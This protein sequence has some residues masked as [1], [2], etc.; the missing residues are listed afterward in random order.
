MAFVA[1]ARED[2]Q[3]IAREL[4]RSGWQ[5][6]GREKHEKQTADHWAINRI[7]QARES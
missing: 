2:R 4:G 7:R 6:R 1:V 5:Q 3:N